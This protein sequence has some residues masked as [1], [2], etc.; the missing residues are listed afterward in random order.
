MS[1]GATRIAA[2]RR[3]DSEAP[4]RSGLTGLVLL[5]AALFAFWPRYLA[6]LGAADAYT[7]L[8]ALLMTA[9]CVLLMAQPLLVRAGRLAWHRALGRSSYVLVPALAGCALLLTHFRMRSVPDDALRVEAAN[10]YL[11][12]SMTALFVAA[13]VL[14]IVFRRTPALHARFMFCTSLSAVDPV[15]GR[16]LGFYLPPLEVSYQALTFG[17]TDLAL[18][19]LIAAERRQGRAR[20]ALPLV[21]ALYL[22]AHL[23]WFTFAPSATWWHMVLWM[24]ALPLT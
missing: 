16:L 7:H 24:R 14:A 9:W 13:Y 22:L 19:A 20:W 17:V 23:L 2:P 10:F 15:L 8:H 6:R 21:L 3:R 18:V 5:V 12:L 1:A 4:Y 11:P